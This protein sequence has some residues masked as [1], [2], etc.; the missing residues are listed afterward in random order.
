MSYTG[1]LMFYK[2]KGCKE[3]ND[4]GYR[5]RMGLYELLLGDRA[6]KMQIIE[7]CLVEDLRETAIKGGMTTLL[8]DGIYHTFFGKTDLKQVTSVC[9][10]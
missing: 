4:V 6:M 5:G 1:D 9:S 10:R 7:R 8:Q 2:P 3:C